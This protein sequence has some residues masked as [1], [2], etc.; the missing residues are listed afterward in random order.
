MLCVECGKKEAKYENLCEDCFLEKVRFTSLPQHIEITVCPHCGAVKFKGE[1]LR[2]EERDALVEAVRRNIEVLHDNDAMDI[3]LDYRY[4]Q[5]EYELNIVIRVRYSDFSVEEYHHSVVHL[6]YE[7]C[8]RCNRYFGNYFEAIIQIRGAREGEIGEL[9]NYAKSRIE[10]YSRKNE[11]LFLTKEERRREGWD[12]YISDKR[13]ARKIAREMCEK[14]GAMLK[15]SPQIAGRKDGND[16]YRVTYSV[17]LPE[18][19]VGDILKVENEYYLLLEILG[20]YLKLRSLK[21]GRYKRVDIRKH[22]VSTVVKNKELEDAMIVYSSGLE[23]QIMDS[24]YLTFDVK[25]PYPVSA[26]ERV[27]IARIGEDIYVVPCR[28]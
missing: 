6:N 17:R 9:V 12:L 5:R 22:R 2:M 23:A 26:G 4:T 19:R 16:I 25:L 13:E 15:E 18:Y 7:S 3:S 14:Y 20:N 8:T 21:D 1:W 27:K 28:K 10:H 11:N 24:H